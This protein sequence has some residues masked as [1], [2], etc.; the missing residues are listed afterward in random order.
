MTRVSTYVVGITVGVGMGLGLYGVALLSGAYGGD[1][2]QFLA[3]FHSILFT[4]WAIDKL[5]A[6][7]E[8]R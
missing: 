3:M 5:E 2:A 7:P 4:V 8:K 6:L 1:P